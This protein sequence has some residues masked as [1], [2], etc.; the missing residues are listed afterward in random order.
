[1]GKTSNRSGEGL[2]KHTVVLLYSGGM[3]S[4]LLL[5]MALQMGEWPY[6]VII[7]YEQVHIKEIQAAERMCVELG[8]EYQIVNIRDLN[9]GSNLTHKT[10]TYDGVSSWHVPA[11]NLMFLAI[12][13]SIAESKKI[14]IIWYGANYEDRENL[15][16]DCYQ[17]WVHQLNILL[18]INGSMKIKVEAPLLGMSK[19]TISKLCELF[20]I[21]KN[22]IFSGYGT[23]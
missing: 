19:E 9:I 1:M 12:S 3:D 20:K 13:A 17:E 18:S 10:Q 7:D 15:F 6:C 4:T 2:I 21:D 22:K 8:V 16:P 23:T 5:K 11:R 14:K